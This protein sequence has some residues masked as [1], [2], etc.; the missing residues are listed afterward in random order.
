VEKTAKSEDGRHHESA[1][2]SDETHARRQMAEARF[3]LSI[4]SVHKTIYADLNRALTDRSSLS[5]AKFDAIAQ[6]QRFPEGLTMGELS[7]LLKVTNGNVS[8]L[9]NRLMNDGYVAKEVSE[10]DR[11][12]FFVALTPK[13]ADAFALAMKAH[14]ETISEQLRELD[15]SDIQAAT[16]TLRKISAKLK[17]R[18]KDE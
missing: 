11:R 17:D 10:D 3:W 2:S 9:V 1:A 15:L 8:G 7:K 4:L 5:L 14:R 18:D 13:G 6:L 12:S 16:A